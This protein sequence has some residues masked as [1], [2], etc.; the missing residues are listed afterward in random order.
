MAHFFREGEGTMV[1]LENGDWGGCYHH[2][3]TVSLRGSVELFLGRGRM[4]VFLGEGEGKILSWEEGIGRLI[5]N[6]LSINLNITLNV[7]FVLLY[8]VTI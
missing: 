8:I 3:E 1:P 5:R 2:T 4:A 6:R 7:I